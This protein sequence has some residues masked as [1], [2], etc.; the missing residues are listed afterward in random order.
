MSAGIAQSKFY[1]GKG[2]PGELDPLRLRLLS[3]HEVV[4]GGVA[5]G[6]RAAHTAARVGDPGGPEP[7]I[8]LG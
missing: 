8:G 3:V 7:A 1:F 6:V 2:S 5:G 4:G